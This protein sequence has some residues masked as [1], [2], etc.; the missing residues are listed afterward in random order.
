VKQQLARAALLLL[1]MT[2]RVKGAYACVCYE[3]AGLAAD[4][5]EAK[6]VFAGK[7]V[8]LETVTAT[9]AGHETENMV[10]VIRVTRRWKGPKDKVI[11]VQTCGTQDMICT[12]GTDFRLGGSYVVFG[13]GDP[14]GTGS[15]QRTQVYTPISS[16]PGMEWLG[17]EDL[18]RD[19]D[20]LARNAEP[21]AHDL[22]PE[23][24]PD[25][26]ALQLTRARTAHQVRAERHS[27]VATCRTA[28]SSFMGPRS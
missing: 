11:R 21:T 13:V 24:A 8:A 25:N 23:T 6:A 5:A 9:V 27:A 3:S 26:N 14:L 18:V 4:V 12:C 17:A 10:A 22:A 7:V 20:A 19:L 1:L 16:E 15:C 2:A 28:R